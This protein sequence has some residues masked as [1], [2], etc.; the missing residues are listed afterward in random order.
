MKTNKWGGS[1]QGP[2]ISYQLSLN[3]FTVCGIS[4]VSLWWR[5]VDCD[6]ACRFHVSILMSPHTNTLTPYFSDWRKLSRSAEVHVERAPSDGLEE[7]KNLSDPHSNV[8]TPSLHPHPKHWPYEQFFDPRTTVLA[9][10]CLLPLPRH[11]L[12]LSW[13]PLSMVSALCY[14]ESYLSQEVCLLLHWLFQLFPHARLTM[15]QCLGLLSTDW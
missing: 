15:T 14:S 4:E 13:F 7:D 5:R 12:L 6:I 11:V 1:L 8:A 10:T 2:S 3:L 9:P